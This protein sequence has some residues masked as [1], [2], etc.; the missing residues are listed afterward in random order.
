MHKLE[1]VPDN[2]TDK[3]FGD[4]EIKT[5]YLILIRRPDFIIIK[6]KRSCYIM[7]LIIPLDH[8]V[9]ITENKMR[10]KYLD[11]VGEV[12]M[13][14]SMKVTV[15]PIVI[16]TLGTVPKAFLKRLEKLEIGG[17]I[18]TIRTTILLK[19]ARILRRFLQAFG[20]FLSFTLLWKTISK[21]FCEKLASG[22]II[23]IIIW[24]S[25]NLNGIIAKIYAD[26]IKIIT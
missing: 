4:F 16:G 15:I 17:G 3:I 13:Q 18:G 21:F 20:N 5:D 23:I 9:K 6:K 10:D 11:L 7:D 24:V 8:R 2:E 19:S 1:S 14:W 26:N 22:R 12:K 25:M